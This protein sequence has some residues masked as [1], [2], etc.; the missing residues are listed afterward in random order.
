MCHLRAPVL[1]TEALGSGELERLVVCELAVN[2]KTLGLGIQGDGLHC[3]GVDTHS[4]AS[5]EEVLVS[6][7]QGTKLRVSQTEGK[8]H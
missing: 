5:A 4:P 3:L 1:D 7:Y 6:L 2:M 8:P